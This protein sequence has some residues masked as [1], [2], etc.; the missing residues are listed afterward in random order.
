M[1]VPA[2][3]LLVVLGLLE[4]DLWY[5][6]GSDNPLLHAVIF[7]AMTAVIGASVHR[8]QRAGLPTP[9]VSTIAR[10][11]G[12]CLTLMACAAVALFA[13]AWLFRDPDE[14][15]RFYFRQRPLAGW[16]EWLAIR[17]AGAVVQQ[18]GLQLFIAP[19]C[20]EIVRRDG[21]AIGAAG[22][23][24]GTLHLPHPIL[25]AITV[26]IGSLW[27]WLCLRSGRIAPVIACH[28][29]L[30]LLAAGT[31]PQSI[32]GDMDIGRESLNQMINPRH[33]STAD[34]REAVELVRT[35]S[36]Y[37][38]NGSTR[39]G[40]ITGIFRD[41][42]GRDPSREEI[43]KWLLEL[44]ENSRARTALSIFKSRAFDRVRPTSIARAMKAVGSDRITRDKP[45]DPVR[46]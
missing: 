24:F 11:W 36:Y 26:T 27:V 38:M 9:G 13:A 3:E 17:A 1:L 6:R 25:V 7:A 44:S 2:A 39:R 14:G 32:I 45:D 30:S 31:L 21:L 15:F 42:L 46:R 20:R 37:A 43:D 40:F 35:Q 8:R 5:V 18:L 22:L 41:F 33:R 10:A 16:L 34:V 23:L 28:A 29:M 4:L 19:V 12:E